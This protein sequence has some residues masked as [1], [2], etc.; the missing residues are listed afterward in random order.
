MTR[1]PNER[2]L[3]LSARVGDAVL[4]AVLALLPAQSALAMVAHAVLS[5]LGA[6]S[7]LVYA[8]LAMAVAAALPAILRR[9][10]RRVGLVPTST[11]WG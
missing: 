7:L 1:V 10:D 2:M 11:P 5:Q 3:L 9:A 6:G 4:P 8:L